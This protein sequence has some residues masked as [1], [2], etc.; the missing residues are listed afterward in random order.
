MTPPCRHSRESGNPYVDG[1]LPARCL[2]RSDRIACAHM[3]GLL[4]RP[5]SSAPK[6]GSATRVPH[7]AAVS[8]ATGFRGV[9]GVWDRSITPPLP[10]KLLVAVPTGRRSVQSLCRLGQA[11]GVGPAGVVALPADHQLP[12]NACHLVGERDGGELGLLAPDEP[13]Q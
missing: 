8:C 12:G 1:P 6:M 11:L 7:R 4:M 9:S 13:E 5:R 10:C 3:Y 2:G